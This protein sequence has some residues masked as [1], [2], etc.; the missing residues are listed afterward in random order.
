MMK[1]LMK[2]SQM[3]V[4]CLMH[5]GLVFN[6]QHVLALAADNDS[7]VA[8]YGDVERVKSTSSTTIRFDLC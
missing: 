7:R 6:G 3:I 8:V 5:A 4:Q 1:P 2:K